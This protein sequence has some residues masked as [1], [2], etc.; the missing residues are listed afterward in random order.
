[1][2]KWLKKRKLNDDNIDDDSVIYHVNEPTPSTSKDSSYRKY[3]VRRKYNDDFLKFGFSFAM[4]DDTSVPE[5]VIC[6]CKLSN[7]AMVP[8]EL[9]RHLDSNHPSLATKGKSYFQKSLSLKSKQVK[10]FE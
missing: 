6:G 1:M 7:C 2:D 10:V 3:V 8:S 5:Y 4:E 9:Q